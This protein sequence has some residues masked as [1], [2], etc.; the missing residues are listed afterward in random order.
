MGSDG[1]YLYTLCLEKWENSEKHLFVEIYDV[2]FD[3][4]TIDQVNRVELKDHNDK[5]ALEDDDYSDNLDRGFLASN[6]KI[7]VWYQGVHLV[8][9]DLET[10]N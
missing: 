6:G 7:L 2:D 1:E 4:G 10:S 3:Q 5:P 9:Y 8:A